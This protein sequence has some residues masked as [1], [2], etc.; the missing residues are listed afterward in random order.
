MKR[1]QKAAVA[2]VAILGVSLTGCAGGAAD[3]G[4]TS[5][6]LT[7]WVMG[8]TSDNFESLVAPFVK[9]T[10]IDVE[11]V[12]VPWD[13]I[14]QKFTT[15]VASANGPDLLQI[16]ISKLRTFADS[17]ALLSLD[18]EA[19]ADY[20][21]LASSNFIDGV[22]GE[23]TA[24]DGEVLS[25]P[26]VSDTRV[27]FYRSDILA[28]AGIDEPPAT[29]DELREDAKAL[30]ARGDGQYGYYVPQWDSALPV[31]MTWDQGGDI[32]D[33]EGNIDFDTA[34][35]ESAVDLYTGLYADGSVPVN[36]DFDQT[37]G[38]IS[39]VTPMLV[40]G[41]YLAA[42]IED[43]APEL[44]GKWNVTTLPKGVAGTSLLAGSNLGVW[45][46]TK[47][48]DGALQLLD[49]LSAPDTQ[50]KWFELDGQ[51]PTVKAALEDDAL[52]SDPLVGVYSEQLA[53]SK[54]L[55]LV[56]NWDGETGKALLD[57]LNAIVLTGADRDET[58]QTLFTTT[59]G[60]SVN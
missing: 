56:P 40:S 23:A 19:I 3:D 54:L 12:A 14:D 1:Y 47:N 38:F 31:A 55:P 15:A 7:V 53:D 60:T 16:G 36:S 10:G 33:A 26:W 37:Q 46:S 57:A 21:N 4:G 35:F 11:A 49:F 41:P 39:G 29:W 34:E 6:P 51:L 9:D 18:E 50:L 52:A 43:A 5:E 42:A 44:E 59:S 20:P 30:T 58:L 24:I 22:A 2:A 8:D 25:M 27:L 28:E 13:S 48:E 17:G 32:V 45:G